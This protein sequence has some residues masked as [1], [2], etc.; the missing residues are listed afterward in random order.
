MSVPAKPEKGNPLSAD[1]IAR[2]IESHNSAVLH[3]ASPAGMLRHHGRGI[4]LQ[5]RPNWA[6]TLR[7]NR[8]V[9]YP[10]DISITGTTAIF[11]A[12][13]ING[14]LPSNYLTGVTVVASGTRYLVLNCTASNGQITAASFEADSS[15]PP[16]LAPTAGQP[17]TS[18]KVLIG[19]S[20]DAVPF[21]VWGSGNIQAFGREMFRLA[22]ASPVAGQL[23]YSIY[24]TWEFSVL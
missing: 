20:I 19:V 9:P 6:A 15:V 11:R 5:R 23:P 21:K 16:A 10:F 17:P 8:G 24:Y 3:H 14:L 4:V 7:S 18:F 12:G 22:V 2:I 13:T 1:A